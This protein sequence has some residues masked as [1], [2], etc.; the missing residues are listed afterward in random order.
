[1]TN[2]TSKHDKILDRLSTQHIETQTW[3]YV[4]TGTRFKVFHTPGTPRDV[5]EKIDDAGLVNRLTGVAPTVALHIP[6][7]RVDDYRVLA[8]YAIE[9]GVRIGSISPN[10]FQDDDFKNGSLTNLDPKR[11]QKAIDHSVEVIEVMRATGSK[12]MSMW[13]ADGTNYPGQGDFRK[14]RSLLLGGLQEIYDALDPDMEMVLEYKLFEPAALRC[15]PAG[16]GHALADWLRSRGH[17]P[18]FMDFPSRS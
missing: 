9:Q 10:L 11:R 7:D 12:K 4:S 5:W 3:G 1:M 17:Q 6:W 2:S 16:T 8:D 14:R 15:W 18:R 13:L